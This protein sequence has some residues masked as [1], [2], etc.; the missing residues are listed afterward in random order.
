MFR[1]MDFGL[2][3]K[4]PN[5][6][7]QCKTCQLLFRLAD[8]NILASVDAIYRSEDYARHNECHQLKVDAF[9]DPVTLAYLQADLLNREIGRQE[10]DVL[11]VGCF[12]GELLKELGSRFANSRR[13][14]FDVGERADFD[15]GPGSEFV[16]RDLRDVTGTFD[17]MTMSH[18]LQYIRDLDVFFSEIDR[19]LKS[20]GMLFIHVPDFSAK[21][22][23]LLLG[24]L[25]CYYTWNTIQNVLNG[26]GF[27]AT[28]LDNHWFPR[29]LL[30]LAR[31]D[32]TVNGL[33]LR[34]DNSVT[35]CIEEIKNIATALADLSSNGGQFAVLGT[36]I[37]A[38]FSGYQLGDCARY[39]VDENP[40]KVGIEFHGK[41][42]KP[43]SS[44]QENDTVIIP[45][46]AAG[47]KIK[48]RLGQK[49]AGRFL[50]V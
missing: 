13:V 16:S 3:S 38:A 23:S 47:Q 49:Y 39:F 6:L 5:Y 33:A 43:P 11:D 8:Q 14:G 19:L 48:T 46:S 45:M 35:Q 40:E 15:G 24:D 10:I 2:L 1:H 7:G 29:D 17:L 37:E 44:I 27:S 34:V 9:P 41:P 50:C 30:V 21:P 25:H 32:D 28:R 31:R 42:V 26:F 20:N 4:G 18:S 22:C 12:N 36:T